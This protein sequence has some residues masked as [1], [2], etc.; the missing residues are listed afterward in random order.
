MYVRAHFV[1]RNFNGNWFGMLPAS[2]EA[3]TQKKAFFVA[4]GSH[5]SGYVHTEKNIPANAKS[6]LFSVLKKEPAAA[7]FFFSPVI[8]LPQ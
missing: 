3:V 5:D 1:G 2:M 6:P 4:V 7:Y 8:L